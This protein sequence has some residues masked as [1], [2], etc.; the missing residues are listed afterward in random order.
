[1]DR[2]PPD[3]VRPSYPAPELLAA[4]LRAR[5][6]RA[7]RSLGQHFLTDAAL[8]DRIA[9][10]AGADAATLAVEIGPGPATL[11]TRLATRAGGVWAVDLDARLTPFHASLFPPGSGVEVTYGDALRV[12]LAGEARA[13]AARAGFS[14]IVLAG[15]LPFQITSPL[16]FAQCAPDAP[17]ERMSLMVQREVA[18]RI[19]AAPGGR[20]YGIL[21]VRLSWRWRVVERFEIPAR[22]FSPPP[23][24]DAT[25]LVFEPA[26]AESRP[27]GAELA[28][29]AKLVDAAFNQRR[30]KLYNTLTERWPGAPPKDAIRA[31]LE[32]IGANPDCRAENLAPEQWRALLAACRER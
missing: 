31:A 10:A 5:G 9:D 3:R 11:T 16:L 22:M 2:E 26:P 32:R 14:R 23:K 30:K 20:E 19:V 25:A 12:D 1:M 13:R 4:M 18:D 24:V 21:S 7:D 27:E 15:N 8:L 17:W 28:A 29:L 6:H